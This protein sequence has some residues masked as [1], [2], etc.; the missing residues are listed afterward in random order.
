M[1]ARASTL[2]S[3]GIMNSPFT[4]N[5]RSSL[6]IAIKRVISSAAAQLDENVEQ[7]TIKEIVDN[8]RPQELLL[9]KVH[10]EKGA[11]F[12]N[13]KGYKMPISYKNAEFANEVL[14]TRRETSVFDASYR[15][16]IY[17]R[18]K[19]ISKIME[20]M[21]TSDLQELKPD[22]AVAT[23]MTN[24]RGGIIDDLVVTKLNE[25]ELHIVAN[26]PK[27]LKEIQKKK[28]MF[29]T[30][31]Q[32]KIPNDMT[33]LTFQ[34]PEFFWTEVARLTRCSD[35][36][37]DGFMMSLPAAHAEEF[38]NYAVSNNSE[39]LLL[40]G[41]RAREAL[42]IEAGHCLSGIDYNEK[43]TPVQAKLD[44][45]IG[46]RRR[47]EGKF[48]GAD[49]ILKELN[50]KSHPILRI[51]FVANDSCNVGA[52]IMDPKGNVIG[53]VTS[54]CFSPCLQQHIGIG[55]VAT[56]FAQSGKELLFD[57]NIKGTAAEMPL[58][59]HRTQKH[60]TLRKETRWM[61][62]ITFQIVITLRRAGHQTCCLAT[63]FPSY[64]DLHRFLGTLILHF[65]KSVEQ[66]RYKNTR[67]NNNN[68]HFSL[69]SPSIGRKMLSR[70]WSEFWRWLS[71]YWR[72]SEL[73]YQA[74]LDFERNFRHNLPRP[75]LDEAFRRLPSHTLHE[76]ELAIYTQFFGF[77]VPVNY[78]LQTVEEEVR[79]SRES[80]TIYDASYKTQFYVWGAD[81][82]RFL[83][84]MV[85]SDIAH[86]VEGKSVVT[87][88]TNYF[89]GIIDDLLISRLSSD[90]FH[91]AANRT[92]VWRE[93]QK[94]VAESRG[95]L[96]CA[97][98]EE[99]C[100]V[101]LQGPECEDF[102]KTYG[103]QLEELRYLECKVIENDGMRGYNLVTR[104][105]YVGEDG[106]VISCGNVS[107]YV[108]DLKNFLY[109]EDSFHPGFQLIGLEAKECLRIEA[110]GCLSTCDINE[111]TTPVEAG[112]TRLI[113]GTKK[114]YGGFPG[115]V[116]VLNQ[117]EHRPKK[118]RAGFSSDVGRIR[119]GDIVRSPD[120]EEIGIVTSATYSPTLNKFI[121][122]GYVKATYH[123]RT[124]DLIFND[125]IP[126]KFASLP[127]VYHR[128]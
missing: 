98:S 26:T 99:K 64:S 52:S 16:Q 54:A 48:P 128:Y 69:A 15:P 81:A 82:P 116:I 63:P 101:M 71:S 108:Q 43:I 13:F 72:S 23:L 93:V 2:F 107:G 113:S 14:F 91:V 95:R 112:L 11:K 50:D 35:T 61:T 75:V 41:L 114:R 127:F 109:D 97:I 47:I 34:G 121:A 84:H 5:G 83:D 68:S 74:A 102:I 105:S 87:V 36:G 33:L 18:G 76:R 32:I 17:L 55:Y 37:E 88:M 42:R 10:V 122:L 66:S 49:I 30:E 20:T 60:Q 78:E 115:F 119:K 58:V 6:S 89:G 27:V 85:T 40:I 70:I 77:H 3:W 29:E 86:M 53:K 104:Y 67:E 59:K 92:K 62:E 7:G 38:L 73:S 117:Y 19:N 45:L 125:N 28:A 118:I 24:P 46:N 8:V 80:V 111:N 120:G 103:T 39:N 57:K 22:Q 106:F 110:G 21:V 123:G 90:K 56:E 96:D 124:H 25:N 65:L 100:Y 44:G 1:I 4:K 94:S 31:V 79:Q 12:T 9:H 126:G 51:G